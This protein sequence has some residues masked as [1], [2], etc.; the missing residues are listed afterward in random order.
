MGESF[1]SSRFVLRRST[2]LCGDDMRCR[3]AP[4]SFTGEPLLKVLLCFGGRRRSDGR[5]PGGGGAAS[6]STG[7]RCCES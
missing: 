4:S 2:W 7:G 3:S 6:A 5:A 1:S